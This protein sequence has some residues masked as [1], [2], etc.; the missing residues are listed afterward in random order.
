MIFVFLAGLLGSMGFGGGTVLIIYLTVFLSMPQTRAQ[1]INLLF[2]LPAALYSVF[3]Y[4]RQGLIVKSPLLP[5]IIS[6]LFG[7]AGGYAALTF[8]K[9]ALLGKL[10]GGFLILLGLRELFSKTKN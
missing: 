1:G 3:S 5:M 7:A 10:F 6:G 9:T 4:R 2:F 8:I